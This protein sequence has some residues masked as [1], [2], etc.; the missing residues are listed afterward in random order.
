MYAIKLELK[1]NN[2]ERTLM[3]RY[4]G[5]ARFCYNFALS[6]YLGVQEL[7]V[8]SSKKVEVV[9]RWYPPSKTCSSCGHIQSMPLKE[10]VFNCEN[11]STAMD[12]DLN[13]AIN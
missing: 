1:L 5:Y 6:L 9:D 4:S 13:A 7:R 3:A 10:R 11:C 2:K 12:R 8:S